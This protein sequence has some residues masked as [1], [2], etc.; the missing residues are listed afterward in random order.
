MPALGQ[1]ATI[2]EQAQR[3]ASGAARPVISAVLAD[4]YYQMGRYADSRRVSAALFQEL[5]DS[6]TA[7]FSAVRA[8]Y[9]ADG[10]DAG[11]TLIDTNLPRFEHNA[12]ALRPVG[13]IAMSYD[14]VDRSSAISRQ[15]IDSGR[16]DISDYNQIAWGDLM[17]GT[18]TDASLEVANRGVQKAGNAPV[19]G[20]LH[21][22]AAVYAV[23]GKETEARATIL[24]RMQLDRSDEPTEADWYVFGLIAE[25]YG[26]HDDAASM[27]RRLKRPGTD[28]GIGASSY[29]LAQRQLKGITVAPESAK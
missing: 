10:R 27:Y 21:T 9:A 14:D 7:W 13:N 6:P 23:L 25:Q 5:P 17:Q 29:A 8:A 28:L 26:L 4:A 16:S 11:R 15:L 12:A 20:L 22:V 1:A 18:V 19:S 3:S 2:L 24:Q